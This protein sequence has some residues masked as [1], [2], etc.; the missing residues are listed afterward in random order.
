MRAAWQHGDN[1]PLPPFVDRIALG[2]RALL[3]SRPSAG[4]YGHLV[5]DAVET[6][7]LA[8]SESAAVVFVEDDRAPNRAVY[9]LDADGVRV[10]GGAGRALALL[11][12]GPV[13]WWRRVA[14][15]Q[16]ELYRR[17]LKVRAGDPGLPPDV[18]R[19]LK[20][21]RARTKVAAG[22]AAPYY[23]RRLMRA[24]PGLS[25]RADVAADARG[26]MRR[27]GVA[28][29]ARLACVHAR[30]AG[31]KRGREAEDGGATRLDSLRNTAIETYDGAIDLLL[32][33]GFTVVRVGDPSMRPIGRDDV[34][35]LA[36]SPLRAPH[37]ELECMLRAAFVLV[38]DSGP[39]AAAMLGDAVYVVANATDVV[40]SYPVR[41]SGFLLAQRVRERSTGRMLSALDFLSE[42]Y[43]AR[44]RDPLEL[45]YLHNDRDEIRAATAE[46]I[47]WLD[48]CAETERQARYRDLATAAAERLGERF[49]YVRKWGADAGFL[50]D[51]RIVDFQLGAFT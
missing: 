17:E 39:H 9:A 37:V 16:R 42:D 45:E 32:D 12:T 51:G 36:V 31:F 6:L 19:R 25:L 30:E 26:T 21:H 23:R 47:G 24:R 22:P 38:G 11:A 14:Q 8:A 20:R 33:S 43:L 15:L 44:L 4:S 29:D 10:L 13:R 18:R 1:G 27:L 7:A 48:G 5:I 35:D 50:G 49:S 3:V 41:S 34:V 28:D 40:T 2:S 46:A